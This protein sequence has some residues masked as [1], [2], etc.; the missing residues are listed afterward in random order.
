MSSVFK[1]KRLYVLILVP[2][3]ILL[4][5]FS[6]FLISSS[7][8]LNFFLSTVNKKISGQLSIDSWLIGWQQGILCQNVVYT[9]TAKGL[10]LNIPTLTST[11]GLMELLLV[12]KNLG[13]VHVDSPEIELSGPALQALFL[14]EK[15]KGKHR[16]GDSRGTP[17]VWDKVIVELIAKNGQV[18]VKS[19][20]NDVA[21]GFRG[22]DVDASLGGGIVT[23]DLGFQSQEKGEAQV[24]G[25]LNLPVHEQDWLETIIAE[26]KFNISSFQVADYVEA[27]Y[28]S[29]LLP[30]GNGILNADFEL[31]AAGIGD[32][33]FNGIA[34][35]TD[36]SLS[37]GFLPDDQPTLRK[38]HVAIDGG[39]WSRVG[40]S[41][42]DFQVTSDILN[43]KGNGD[44]ATAQTRIQT[45]GNMNLPVLFD[46]VPEFL[47]VNESTFLETGDV[48]FSIDASL[49][50]EGWDIEL[51]ARANNIGGISQEQRF[52]W[53]APA[54]LQFQGS[55][56][57]DNLE[58]GSLKLD[59]PFA[60][61]RG[62]GN[63]HSFSMGAMLDVK[64]ALVDLGTL[65]QIDMTGSGT[66]ELKL[67]SKSA[68]NE[69]DRFV[70]DVDVN[71]DDF[72]LA[73]EDR[74]IVPR[75]GLSLI[76][77]LNAPDSY[78]S[79]KQ[80]E[81]GLQVALSS[82]LGEI[83]LV[84]NGEKFSSAPFKWYFTTDSEVNLA[85]ASTLLQIFSVV[86]DSV[87]VAGDAQL[88]AAGFAGDFPLEIRD[89]AAEV[90]GFTLEGNGTSLEE[91]QVSIKINQSVN[92]EI[93]Y[94]TVRDLHV[95]SSKEIFFRDGAGVN[96]VDFGKKNLVLH[97]IVFETGSG[98][99]T[100]EKLVIPNWQK[101]FENARG[102]L[103]LT[104]DL[105]QVAKG[106]HI[107]NKLSSDTNLSGPAKL[108]LSY[109][110]SGGFLPE[111]EFDLQVADLEWQQ[112]NKTII[113]SDSVALTGVVQGQVPYG[114]MTVKNVKLLSDTLELEATG[115]VTVQGDDQLL[116][117][118]G[119]MMPNLKT[120]GL[121]IGNEFNIDLQMQGN[122]AEQ[123]VLRYPLWKSFEEAVSEVS[124]SSTLHAEQLVYNGI[125]LFDVA[126]P[127]QFDNSMLHM[128]VSGRMNEGRL[129]LVAVTD[130]VADPPV[131]KIPGNNQVLTGVQLT[132][133]LTETVLSKVHPLF[134]GLTNPS[135]PVDV[136]VDSFWWPVGEEGR[137]EV[138]F[139]AIFDA[140]EIQ[141]QGRDPLKK[142]LA[143]V[144][145]E[146]EPLTLQDTEIYCI[147]KNGR[148]QCSPLHIMAGE[149]ELIVGGSVGMDGSLDYTVELPF[150]KK[151][152]SDEVFQVLEGTTINIALQGTTAEPSFE[153]DTV[154]ST[155]KKLKE[156]A[157]KEIVKKSAG[158][159]ES[160]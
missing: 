43:V 71:I 119:N 45:Q 81:L 153:E 65:F 103:A 84:M 22:V 70:A 72:T 101:P 100:V 34:E 91:P 19:S 26:T 68:E 20:D 137:N 4:V 80:G 90:T 107:F 99:S 87:R 96:Q 38:F 12:P 152:V 51:K 79:K 30:L 129:E 149:S 139:V 40:W 73:Y 104:M 92:D 131:I 83:F 113:D 143:I 142:I 60:R 6:P 128:E 112:R 47:N 122:S 66:M 67:E 133:P 11:R 53:K 82:W 158:E 25:T 138:N 76:G 77:S 63:P 130:Y 154:T 141:L 88:Q 75:H 13:V 35:L 52:S 3:F 5:V 126:V 62:N 55:R 29:S 86:E 156:Q 125:E 145:L 7:K 116:E 95:A 14:A 32:L 28:S 120:A 8:S 15:E 2:I 27:V 10:K 89:F 123:F 118:N 39:K 44:S 110:G 78:I 41:V 93:P 151:I 21:V 106:L 74:E 58:V 97:N 140:R 61:I 48:V 157:E 144:G 85:Q 24:S 114:D 105:E 31:K 146:K 49:L 16:A 23:F 109:P 147:G 124:I 117:L 18:N 136:R 59:A 155:V 1:K 54:S 135:G 17:P 98:T 46:Q 57:G 148:I 102:Q 159:S 9:D 134:G 64:Q 160:S 121:A 50:Q 108:N 150:T 37:G 36:V 69:K 132:P 42:N 115:K 56:K 111:M 94:L 33:E 127:Y